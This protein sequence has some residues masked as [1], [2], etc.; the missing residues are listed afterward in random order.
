MKYWSGPAT[1][2]YE[3]MSS[4]GAELTAES[5]TPLPDRS[6]HARHCEASARW[7]FLQTVARAED[8]P[9]HRRPAARRHTFPLPRRNSR[10][11]RRRE[12]RGLW[13]T[14]E[15]YAAIRHR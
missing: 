7:V 4:V 11:A 15:G 12:A 14:R 8:T 6:W 13:T 3:C 10:G 2:T 1:D 9:G 5:A